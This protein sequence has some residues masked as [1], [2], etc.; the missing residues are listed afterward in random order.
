RGAPGRQGL[1]SCPMS[2]EETSANSP[3]R[4]LGAEADFGFCAV[5]GAA[6]VPVVAPVFESVAGR[7]DLMNDLMSAGI[8]RWW[9]AEMVRALN[10]R[11]GR[12]L[13]ARAGGTWDIARRALTR[14]TPLGAGGAA[15]VCDAN[16]EML[17]VGRAGALDDGILA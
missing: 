1:L 4:P 3:D 17:E 14:L 8:Q 12:R 15:I 16:R 13:L 9:K 5:P 10:T 6:A 11:P 2:G 7:Y